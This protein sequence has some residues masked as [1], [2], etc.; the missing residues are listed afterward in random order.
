MSLISLFTFDMQSSCPLSNSSAVDFALS[1]R[2]NS[3]SDFLFPSAN[4]RGYF[5]LSSYQV[6]LQCLAATL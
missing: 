4:S 3:P 5:S 1:V 6:S 2:L